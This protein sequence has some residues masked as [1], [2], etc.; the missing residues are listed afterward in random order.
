MTLTAKTL[1]KRLNEIEASST[2]EW[3]MK[4]KLLLTKL[5][6][7]KGYEVAVTG[8]GCTWGAKGG[9]GS[10]WMCDVIWAD[11]SKD[12]SL[13]ELLRSIPL[14]AECEW[15]NKQNVWDDFQKLLVIRAD[16]RVLIFECNSRRAASRLVEEFKQQIEVFKSSQKGDKYL[17]ASYV[18]K[19]SPP[20]FVEKYVYSC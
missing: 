15:G 12:K 6:N 13:G 3:T 7:E 16:I 18:E 1:E 10:E 4:V 11:L 2:P 14:A 9:K 8:E 20:F 17:F 5:G 19:E